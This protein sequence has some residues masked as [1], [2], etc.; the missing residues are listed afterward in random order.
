MFY[1]LINALHLSLESLQMK[2]LKRSK[3][4]DM[5]FP[6]VQ[7]ANTNILLKKTHQKIYHFAGP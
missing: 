5:L 3:V 2:H 4:I 6:L 1:N 7:F